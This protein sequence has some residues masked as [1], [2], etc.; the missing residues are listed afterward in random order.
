M[1]L[2]NMRVIEE[3]CT[4]SLVL[5]TENGAGTPNGVWAPAASASELCGCMVQPDSHLE[6]QWPDQT[7]ERD[8]PKATRHHMVGHQRPE[9]SIDC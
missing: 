7:K 9:A 1:A 3:R 2:V 5:R 8:D 6:E 4:D